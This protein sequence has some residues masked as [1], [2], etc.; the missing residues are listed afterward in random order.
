MIDEAGYQ[1]YIGADTFTGKAGTT[2]TIKLA[3]PSGYALADGQAMPTA[4]T[5][6][7]TTMHVLVQSTRQGTDELPQTGNS[8]TSIA[9]LAG[10]LLVDGLALLGI[11]K[12]KN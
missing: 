2:Q 7:G 8:S 11:S 4:I 1:H 6:D 10:T 12:K 9:A 3:L 5:F